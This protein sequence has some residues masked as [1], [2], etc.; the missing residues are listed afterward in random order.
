MQ[1]V[2]LMRLRLL[3]GMVPPK[4]L[5]KATSK[6][7]ELQVMH[8]LPQLLQMVIP[9][10]AGRV[11]HSAAVGKQGL[12]QIRKLSNSAKISKLGSKREKISSSYQRHMHMCS[13]RK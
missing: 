6:Q 2:L 5:A 3:V 13:S 8:H 4:G 12:V 1:G 10:L 11:V 7:L 9:C